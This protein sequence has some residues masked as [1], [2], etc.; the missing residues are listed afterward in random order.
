MIDNY[1]QSF[2]DSLRFYTLSPCKL[3]AFFNGTRPSSPYW[4]H[5]LPSPTP[6]ADYA[7][8]AHPPVR[9]LKTSEVTPA[10]Y[11]RITLT[12][13]AHHNECDKRAFPAFNHDKER[14]GSYQELVAKF[15]LQV[16][17]NPLRRL[18]RDK[19]SCN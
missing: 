17:A 10:I 13:M 4:L 1:L 2:V 5:I 9:Y 3:R 11:G 6:I 16:R 12:G 19:F 8:R 7:S 15:V 18:M 14:F